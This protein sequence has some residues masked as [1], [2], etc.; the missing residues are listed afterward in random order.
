MQVTWEMAYI[1]GGGESAWI[2]PVT[3]QNQ[4]PEPGL[5]ALTSL[6]LSALAWNARRARRTS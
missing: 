4:T 1:N 2:A 6:G 5:L 3:T